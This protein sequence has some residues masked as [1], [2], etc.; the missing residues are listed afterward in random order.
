MSAVHVRMRVGGE[1]YALPVENV[2]EVAELG[3]VAPVPGAPPAVLGVCNLRGE[4]LTVVDLAAIFGIRHEKAP[5][6]L[7]VA[8]DGARRAGFAVDEVIDVGDLPD[9]TEPT[10]SAFLVGA[11]LADGSLVGLIEIP[12]VLDAL[13]RGASR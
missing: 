2:I 13:D 8:E 9:A 11:A 10:E 5:A 6:R 3:D 12:R 1:L 4:V 7:V